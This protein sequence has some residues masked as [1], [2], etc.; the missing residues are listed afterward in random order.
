MACNE[1]SRATYDHAWD[2]GMVVTGKCGALACKIE[3][4]TCRCVLVSA[5]CA[6]IVKRYNECAF[7]SAAYVSRRHVRG[8]VGRK[9]VMCTRPAGWLSSIVDKTV[10]STTNGMVWSFVYLQYGCQN[11]QPFRSWRSKV[12]CWV[13]FWQ[14]L[15]SYCM[16]L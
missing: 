14:R 16:C 11:S 4:L 8:M 13:T 10:A 12:N 1:G 5:S 3:A 15:L 9:G 7:E 6:V 2:F